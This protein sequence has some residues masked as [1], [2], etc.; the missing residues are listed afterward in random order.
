VLLEKLI[1]VFL[2]VVPQRHEDLRDLLHHPRAERH[3]VLLDERAAA[4]TPDEPPDIRVD[5]GS[6]NVPGHV[7][8]Q[9]F[10]RMFVDANRK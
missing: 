1:L 5:H 9:I 7:R 3:S 8:A 6:K 2:V 10:G 4:T